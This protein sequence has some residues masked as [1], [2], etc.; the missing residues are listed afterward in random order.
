MPLTLNGIKFESFEELIDWLKQ[1]IIGATDIDSIVSEIENSL[2]KADIVNKDNVL[3]PD[4]GGLQPVKGKF[5]KDGGVFASAAVESF[6]KDGKNFLRVFLLNTEI[7][8]NF[9]LVTPESIST[10][11]RTFVNMPFIDDQ[12]NNPQNDGQKRHF[13]AENM[14]ANEILRIQESFRIGNIID[15]EIRE[16]ESG[17]ELYAI[18][19]ITDQKAFDEINAG[20][21]IFVSPAIT[22]RPTRQPCGTLLYDQ[23]HGLHLARVTD[24]AYGIMRASIKQT[25][26]GPERQCLKSLISSAASLNISFNPLDEFQ[27]MSTNNTSTT[28]VASE[29]D[30]K[31]LKEEN[32]SL[33]QKL[34]AATE[35]VD[36]LEKK[37][38]QNSQIATE[39]KEEVAT[40]KAK[41]AAEEEEQ[42]KELA[43]KIATIEKEDEVENA[44]TE[45]ELMKLDKEE[46]ARKASSASAFHAKLASVKEN[47]TANAS[48][49]KVVRMASTPSTASILKDRQDGKKL[50]L[51]QVMEASQ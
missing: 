4:P 43:S 45:E 36:M 25:C 8:K 10:F 32:A 3:K 31:K 42:K 38:K 12:G 34:A 15:V 20:Q 29:D 27:D 28:S 46:L 18:V 23:W 41:V 49:T 11:A 5:K 30:V 48:A 9:W 26:E 7:N 6:S 17:P 21:G 16:V 51:A 19:E 40:L 1:N 33:T 22:G 14:P 50:T 24:P 47:S 2:S 39:V 13:G 37:E 44:A 35:T